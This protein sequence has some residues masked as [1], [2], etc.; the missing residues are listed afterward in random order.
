MP[1]SYFNKQEDKNINKRNI[2][3]NKLSSQIVE[4]GINID[5]NI[6]RLC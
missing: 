5:C 4:M 6:R 3:I 2:Y 1:I